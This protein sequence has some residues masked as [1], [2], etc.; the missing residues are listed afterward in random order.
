[1]KLEGVDRERSGTAATRQQSYHHGAVR[2]GLLDAVE[3]AARE[4]G[5]E[6]VTL[7]GCARRVGVSHAA[8]FRHFRDKRALLTA[9]A[10]RSARRLLASMDEHEA[11]APYNSE[12]FLHTG[13]GYVAFAL[14]EPAAFRA[15]FREALLDADDL[16]YRAALAELADRLSRGT[17]GADAGP[18]GGLAPRVLLA[19]ASVHGLGMLC[20]DGS[21][22]RNFP[23]GAE[24]EA[25]TETLRLLGPVL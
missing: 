4:H 10:T 1:M 6:G 25:V 17:G 15:V 5:L 20:A 23:K 12:H 21:L 11:A 16:D 9:F 19:W 22:A 13:V 18:D 24:I 2:E 14:R 7:R 8:A 3:A